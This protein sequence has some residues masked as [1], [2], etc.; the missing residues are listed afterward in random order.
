MSL[1]RNVQSYGWSIA[2]FS[3]RHD[4][5][6]QS[7]YNQINSGDLPIIKIGRKTRITPEGEAAWLEKKVVIKGS[8]A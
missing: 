8:A 7:V 3:F 2:E 4:L 5:C 6:R 1:D